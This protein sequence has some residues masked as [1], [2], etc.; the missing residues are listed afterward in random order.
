MSQTFLPHPLY[1]WFTISSL[2]LTG[3]LGWSL[4][5]SITLTEFFFFLLS[6]TISIWFGNAL[7]SRIRLQERTITLQTPL[8][9]VQE[10]DFGQL[11]SAAEAGRL[12]HSLALLYH[13]RQPDGL[14][15][16]ERIQLLRLPAVVDQEQLLEAIEARILK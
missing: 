5:E 8:R 13:P 1:R 11:V 10:V 2:L 16:L 3:L 12:M 9:G 6:A 14:L 4:I 15:D 7:F